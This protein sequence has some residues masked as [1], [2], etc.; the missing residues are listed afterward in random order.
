MPTAIH[1][2]PD[3]GPDPTS[4]PEQGQGWLHAAQTWV[5]G[6]A[7]T[8]A[9]AVLTGLVCAILAYLLMRRPRKT[10][11]SKHLMYV[12]L[13]LVNAAAIYGQVAFFYEKVAPAI[14]PIPAKVALSLLIAAA[15]ESVAVYVGWHA[16][17]A[18]IMKA[19]ATAAKLRRASYGVAAFVGLI[20]YWHFTDGYELLRPTA[21]SFA[22]GLLSL[23]SPWLWGLH[24]RRVQH[25]QLAREGVVDEAGA[26]FS[27]E[28]IRAFPFRSYMARRWSIDNYVTDPRAAWEGYN[29]HLR[30][31]RAFG[32]GIRVA[33][34]WAVLTGRLDIAVGAAPGRVPG[35][36]PDKEPDTRPAIVSGSPADIAPDNRPAIESG[37][38]A[39]MRPVTLSGINGHT[40]PGIVPGRNPGGAPT[41]TPVRKRTSN[42][43]IGRT[44]QPTSAQ[45]KAFKIRDQNPD[46]TWA[47]LAARVGRNERTVRRWFEDK[48]KNTDPEERAQAPATPPV[49]DLPRVPVS[50]GVNGHRL[51]SEEN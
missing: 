17:D 37:H 15:I 32:P 30:D 22:F 45:L 3:T 11:F 26:T 25:R 40:V 44:T 21:A 2:M 29:T 5:E 39:D 36:G 7:G 27:G 47:Q 43:G 33:R 49:F 9:I 8:I 10:D 24:T 38:S 16:H 13:L 12:P 1:S 35:T 31:R 18:L 48:N 14:W 41:R 34:A 6:M 46:I 42:P 4:T 20:N 50:A 28:R 19:S 23:I 51:T